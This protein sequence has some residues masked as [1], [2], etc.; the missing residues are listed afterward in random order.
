MVFCSNYNM[1][2][3]YFD[4]DYSSPK[5]YRK[6]IDDSVVKAKNVEL[7]PRPLSHHQFLTSKLPSQRIIRSRK[8]EL[9][10]PN[11]EHL[12]SSSE[13]HISRPNSEELSEDKRTKPASI[14]DE[15]QSLIIPDSENYGSFYLPPE[16]NY[17]FQ[18]EAKRPTFWTMTHNNF[19]SFR[20]SSKIRRPSY[21][22]HVQKI[23]LPKKY[24]E[25]HRFSG[26]STTTTVK[27]QE[28]ADADRYQEVD[29]VPVLK[30][31][32]D[33]K[34]RINQMMKKYL[35]SLLVGKYGF[36]TNAKKRKI[37]KNSSVNLKGPKQDLQEFKFLNADMLW[38]LKNKTI[39][40]I[41][42][43]FSLFTVVK[44]NNTEC[45]ATNW[46]GTW[47]GVCLTTT[48]CT[49][50]SGIGMG[51]CASGYGVCCVF[52]GSCGDSSSRNCSYFKSPNYPDFYP[53]NGGTVVPTTTA[54]P[55]TFPTPDPRKKWY[56]YNVNRYQIGES[57]QTNNDTTPC[58]FDVYKTSS[59][60]QQIRIDFIDLDLASPTNGTCVDEMLVISGQNANDQI[61]IICGYNTGQHVYVDV[62]E[63]NGPLQIMVLSTSG[64]RKRFKIKVC[65]YTDSCGTS[66]SNCLQYYTGVRGV[67]QSFNY[68]QAAVF[69]RSS[70][71]YFNALNYAICIRR[72][73]GYCSITFSNVAN[74]QTYPFQMVNRLPSGDLTVPSGQAGVDVLN[75]PDDYIVIDGTRLCG[76]RFNDGS[77]VS[78][79][80]MDASVVD[81]STGPIVINVRTNANVTGLGFKLF[82]VQ[83]VCSAS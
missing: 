45:N 40:K 1:D 79:F 17:D 28:S 27:V 15:T 46:A 73:A 81:T 66:Q 9:H 49:Q 60:V 2:P 8:D 22:A 55:T 72:E 56:H 36:N 16:L 51:D 25:P 14:S 24:Q 34:K 41:K 11:I 82:Y 3:L 39:W 63:L 71:G 64:A 32:P 54:V 61:P 6:P 65:Q 19:T 12:F 29:L 68:D 26:V 44:F 7:K 35:S 58:R 33:T 47:Q 48:E 77:T 67:I 59:N 75:C 18:S 42:Q 78:D 43:F 13:G 83:N 23:D 37:Y 53:S 20:D 69:N 80:T 74:R 4:Y 76:D 31:T 5:V 38:D 10:F 30:K 52:R 50:W 70:P 21:I 57:R 62:S